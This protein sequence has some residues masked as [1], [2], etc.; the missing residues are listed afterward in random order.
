MDRNRL[1]RTVTDELSDDQVFG[2]PHEM[3]DADVFGGAPP[4]DLQPLRHPG[5][6]EAIGMYA[7]EQ[8]ESIWSF[9]KLPGDVWSAGMKGEGDPLDQPEGQERAVGLAGLVSGFHKSVGPVAPV[10]KAF[11]EQIG[12]P[13]AQRLDSFAR[14]GDP[15]GVR[16]E[17]PAPETKPSPIAPIQ[18][19]P[20]PPM[21]RSVAARTGIPEVDAV[22]DHPTVKAVIDNPVVDREHTIPYEAGGSVPLEKPT[23]YLDK[24]VPKTFTVSR[25]SDPSQKVTFDPAEPTVIHENVEEFVMDRLIKAGWAAPE[26]YRVAHFGWAEE[27]EHAWYRAHDIDPAAAEAE[28]KK[29]QPGIQHEIANDTPADLYHKEYPGGSVT[30]ARHEDVFESQP[31]PDELARARE[32]IRNDPELQPRSA[33][34]MLQEAHDL[35]VIGWDAPENINLAAL[36]AKEADSPAEAAFRAVPT[37]LGAQATPKDMQGTFGHAPGSYDARG[38]EWIDKIDDTDSARASIEQIAKSYDYFPESRSGKP[39]AASRAAV[40]EAAGVDPKDIESG[41]F[42][43]HFDSDGKVRAVIQALRQTTKDFMDASEKARREPTDENAA[44]ALEAQERQRNVLEYTMGARAESGRSLN[45]WK[46]LLRETE[47]SNAVTELR[48]GEEPGAAPKDGGAAKAPEVPKGVSDLVQAASDLQANPEKPGG[49]QRLVDAAQKLVDAPAAE[50][51]KPKSQLPPDLAGLVDEA[52]KALKSLKAKAEKP[53]KG[54]AELAA[55]RERLTELSQ[56]KGSVLDTAEAAKKLVAATAKEVKPGAEPVDAEVKAAARAR[57]KLMGAAQKMADAEKKGEIKTPSPKDP[58]LAPLLDSARVA[59]GLLKEG[60]VRT[61]TGAFRDALAKFRSGEGTEEELRSASKALTDALGKTDRSAIEPRA[62]VELDKVASIAR[63]FAADAGKPPKETLPADLKQLVDDSKSAISEINKHEKDVLGNLIKSAEKQAADMVKQKA[64]RKPVDALPPELQ[65][66]VDKSERVV[67]RFG[68]IAKGEKAALLL[69]RAGRTA[70][71]QAELARQVEGLTPNQVARVLKRLR[72]DSSPGWLFWTVQQGLISGLITHTKY[73]IVNTASSIFDRVIAPEMAAIAGKVRGDDV[74]LMA[75]LRAVPELFKAVPDALEGVKQAFKTGT[76]VPL[77]SELKLAERGE[78]NP[79]A[80]G[81]LI[82]YSSR[83]PDW[84]MWKRVFNE[85]QLANAEKVIGIP[86]RSAN[87]IHTFFKILNERAAGGTRAYEKAV[88]EGTTNPTEFW[89]RYN[90]HLDNPTDADL[91]ANI[92]DAYSGTFMEKLGDQSEKF[93]SLVRNTP[94]KWLIFFTHI[95]MNMLRRGIEYSP[96]ALLNTL[97]ETKMGSAIKGELGAPAQNLAFSKMAVGTAVGAYFIDK[98]LSGKATGDYP[99]DPKERRRWAME[100]IQPNSIQADGQWIS[101]ERLG[102]QATVARIAANYAAIIKNYDGQDDKALMTAGLSFVLG[103]AGALAD[104]V[105]FETIRNIVNVLENPQEAARFAAWQLSSYA[106]P[107]SLVTQFASAKD[108]YMRQADTI[109][110]GLKYHIPALRETLTAKRDPLYGEPVPNPGYHDILRQSP[111]SSDPVKA[112]LDRLKYYPTAPEK[113]IGGVRLTSEQYDRYE[114][115]AGPL[116]K[117]MLSAAV[118]GPNYAEMPDFE[119]QA[120]LKSII[121]AGRAR[122]RAAM[123]ADDAEGLL[124]KGIDARK[125][126]MENAR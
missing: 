32:A 25:L 16:M 4:R 89:D 119:K 34:P 82:P 73:A 56:G 86:G 74:S 111:V 1:G 126:R 88:A 10:V 46:E 44:A 115:T 118:N 61:E 27:A 84:G 121:G 12:A 63:R 69:A 62:L 65:A 49:L 22:L 37:A 78:A 26:A 90:H 2:A 43:E 68:G 85:T 54:D 40:A 13:A 101:L 81:A 47:R 17:P 112:E 30:A 11:D 35:G 6:G 55:F 83:G 45:A 113:T 58:E 70:A 52:G 31:T 60:T 14:T 23:T 15:N 107:V 93:A 87:S 3:S 59:T 51:A 19:S 92:E 64:V 122:A 28:W 29:I 18:G 109:L 116:V 38:K 5:L 77:E 120:M 8:A 117:Q 21:P 97:G 24:D 106:M 94:L 53:Q 75:P 41:Y 99:T 9:M 125:A 124:Q 67:D 50:G 80:A 103:T 91:K 48:K 95:P 20:S 33:Q 98:A 42:A 102:P 100:G 123:Q 96:I 72:G 57:S 39:S 110:D 104:D 7:K 105:G 108:P 71:E 114:A 76:R 66:L 79:E 36:A